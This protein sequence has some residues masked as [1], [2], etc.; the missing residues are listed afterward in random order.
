METIEKHTPISLKIRMLKE[1]H[2]FL[3]DLAK[4]QGISVNQLC[5]NF[6]NDGI[7]KYN[8][9][10]PFMGS[11]Q[12]KNTLSS[13]L[14]TH[15]GYN[16]E[17]RAVLVKEIKNIRDKVLS[18]KTAATEMIKSFDTSKASP[19]ELDGVENVFPVCISRNNGNVVFGRLKVPSLKI[20]IT[21]FNI[22]IREEDIKIAFPSTY[23]YNKDFVYQRGRG[24][25]LLTNFVMKEEDQPIYTSEIFLINE[26]LYNEVEEI[27]NNLPQGIQFKLEPTY[28]YL[29]IYKGKQPLR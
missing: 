1:M 12:L 11:K 3:V 21:D 22:K 10:L 9:D 20:V 4:R 19:I 16:A 2:M 5:N 29:I 6:L 8:F 18:M 25:E 23:I 27:G 26:N 28:L 17:D 14:K 13:L 15:P 24:G 7:A